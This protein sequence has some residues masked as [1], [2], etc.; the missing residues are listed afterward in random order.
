GETP[1]RRPQDRLLV[2]VDDF[3]RHKV[4]SVT[5]QVNGGVV[6]LF[7][8]SAVRERSASLATLPW[9][10]GDRYRIRVVLHTG[11]AE[12]REYVREVTLRYEPSPPEVT[13][14]GAGACLVVRK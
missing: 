6:R 11:E 14:K 13:M 3:P 12:P 7:D 4:A 10:P 9:K 1:V 2:A 8:A 5:W